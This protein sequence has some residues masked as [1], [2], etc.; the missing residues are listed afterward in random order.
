MICVECMVY[1]DPFEYAFTYQT[2][3]AEEPYFCV[4]LTCANNPPKFD[5]LKSVH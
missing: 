4:C 3:E 2:M 5:S 1:K